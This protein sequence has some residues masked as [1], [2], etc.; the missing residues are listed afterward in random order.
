MHW[1]INQ[2][3]KKRSHLTEIHIDG[4]AYFRIF[5]MEYLRY[6]PVYNRVHHR[7]ELPE[8]PVHKQHEPN[9]ILMLAKRNYNDL[10]LDI[11]HKPIQKTIF[12]RLKFNLLLPDHPHVLDKVY[13]T[14]IPTVMM[15]PMIYH[16]VHLHCNNLNN[17][18]IKSIDQEIR[19]LS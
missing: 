8:Q 19:L 10:L 7:R 16:P 3:H 18:L 1:D 9:W 5:V 6:R 2:H 13:K 15:N 17:L 4:M 12:I 14:N 11:M